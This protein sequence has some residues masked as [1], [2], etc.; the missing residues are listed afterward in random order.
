MGDSFDAFKEFTNL[1]PKTELCNPLCWV[2]FGGVW[3]SIALGSFVMCSIWLPLT[4]ILLC[5]C[6]FREF[7]NEELSLRVEALSDKILDAMK[8]P[9]DACWEQLKKICQEHETLYVDNIFSALFPVAQSLM[10]CFAD[11]MN[12]LTLFQAGFMFQACFL[13]C[14]LSLYLRYVSQYLPEEG[15]LAD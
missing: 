3:Q 4:I 5:T 13:L 1:N 8:K 10:G 12:A 15:L 14:N 2:A 6:H 9:D 11:C 7:R